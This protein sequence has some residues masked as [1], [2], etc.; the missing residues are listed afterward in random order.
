MLTDGKKE[1]FDFDLV[2]IAGGVQWLQVDLEAERTI[3]A[4]VVWHNH[5][6]PEVFQKSVV[7]QVADDAEFT[8]NVR[9]LFNNDYGNLTGLGVGTDKLY[10]ENYDGKLIDAKGIKARYLRFYSNGSNKSPLNT[11]QEIEVWGLPA[12]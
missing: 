7:V 5:I 8:K 3:Y 12:R 4:I 2:E 11:Y 9:T 1:A 10:F 6:W